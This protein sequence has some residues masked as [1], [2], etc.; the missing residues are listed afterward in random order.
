M[1]TAIFPVMRMA[2]LPIAAACAGC[3][4]YRVPLQPG[5]VEERGEGT[6]TLVELGDRAGAPTSRPSVS[7][8]TAV[9][10]SPEAQGGRQ[11]LEIGL[12]AQFDDPDRPAFSTTHYLEFELSVEPGTDRIVGFP[13]QTAMLLARPHRNRAVLYRFSRCPEPVTLVRHADGTIRGRLVFEMTYIIALP[14]GERRPVRVEVE[15]TAERDAEML[16]RL[17]QTASAT[18]RGLERIHLARTA[19]P[20]AG[21][22]DS[23]LID[24]TDA[25]GGEP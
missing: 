11:A 9:F 25:E 6:I 13:A 14:A 18:A 5:Q 7:L 1:V 19:R 24:P 21:R 12:F 17:R 8:T 4:L 16:R 22:T 2:L 23:E 20:G 10:D 3:Y 15:F